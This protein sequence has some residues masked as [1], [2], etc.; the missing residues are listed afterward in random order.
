MVKCPICGAEKKTLYSHVFKV[1]QLTKEEFSSLYPNVSLADK[2]Y[3][4]RMS[5]VH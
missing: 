2:E 4:T 3:S 5:K 1:H